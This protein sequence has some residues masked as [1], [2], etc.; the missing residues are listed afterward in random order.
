MGC[1]SHS[2]AGREENRRVKC[3]CEQLEAKP[4]PAK[5]L[6]L[7]PWFIESARNEKGKPEV[8]PWRETQAGRNCS[9]LLV[10]LCWVFLSPQLDDVIYLLLLVLLLGVDTA[11]PQVDLSGV[12]AAC[13]EEPI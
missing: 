10:R 6:R 11:P 1:P 12:P 7:I 3:P 9:P 4:F 13:F 5:L 2:M 8:Q